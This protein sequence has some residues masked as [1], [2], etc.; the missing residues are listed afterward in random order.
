MVWFVVALGLFC[1]DCY[2][3]LYRWLVPWK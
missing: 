2:R 1:T 3:Q